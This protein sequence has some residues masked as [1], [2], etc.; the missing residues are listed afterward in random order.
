MSV[1]Q[2]DRQEMAATSSR[3]TTVDSK[4]IGNSTT[5]SLH[6]PTTL[7]QKVVCPARYQQYLF[8]FL[9]EFFI[10]RYH[11]NNSNDGGGYELPRT[12]RKLLLPGAV[13]ECKDGGIPLDELR[14]YVDETDSDVEYRLKQF[15]LCR[16]VAEQVSSYRV[17]LVSEHCEQ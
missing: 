1:L 2:T 17:C 11:N 15:P 13:D 3:I 12:T 9:Y 16:Y 6:L 4:Y 8:T 14:E 10:T 7:L 5:S